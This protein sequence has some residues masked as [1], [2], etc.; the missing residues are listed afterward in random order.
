[1]KKY[2]Y[3]LTIEAKEEKEAETK[4]TALTAVASMLTATELTKLAHILKHDP[5]KTT[6]AKKY[7]KA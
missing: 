2:V 5:V 3:E 1:M 7:L 4:M 6:L